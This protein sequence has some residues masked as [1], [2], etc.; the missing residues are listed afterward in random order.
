[1]KIHIIA[2]GKKQPDWVNRGFQEYIKRLNQEVTIQLKEIVAVTHY[3]NM[4]ANEIKQKEACKIRSAIPRHTLL[5]V[6]DE[7][8]KSLTSEN[9][10][11]EMQQW[12][13]SGQDVSLVIGGAEGLEKKLIDEADNCWSLSTFTLP[14]GLVRILL[15]EQIYRAWSIL[16]C[17]PYHRS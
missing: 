7:Q 4:T 15:A 5:I 6:L 16:K 17:H 8:G 10:A 9:L 2:V 1:M 11:S 14:H 13:D 12:Q 3:K